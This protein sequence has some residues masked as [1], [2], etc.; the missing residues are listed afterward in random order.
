METLNI[1]LPS[2]PLQAEVLADDELTSENNPSVQA[3]ALREF[4]NF[5]PTNV[6][7]SEYE[8]DLRRSVKR[9]TE[10]EPRG[11]KKVKLSGES[12]RRRNESVSQSRGN[13]DVSA[14][15]KTSDQ[16]RNDFGKDPSSS[17]GK[18]KK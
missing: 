13:C 4:K 16:T 2:Q 14:R 5:D 10:R 1:P 15:V 7:M 3:Q 17:H 11:D 8:E 9:K 12:S 18:K 6:D